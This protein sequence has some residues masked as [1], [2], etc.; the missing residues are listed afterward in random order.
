MC[1]VSPSRSL[2]KQ[3]DALGSVCSS[4]L[5]VDMW[6]EL[7]EKVP[8]VLSR[9]HRLFKF[10]FETFFFLKSRCPTKRRADAAT[11]ARPPFG[12]ATT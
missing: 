11:R 1:T 10:S 5:F 8:N 3:G 12:M 7:C 4:V 9:C 2:A 6:A